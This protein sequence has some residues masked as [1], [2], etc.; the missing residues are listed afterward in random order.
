ME[1]KQPVIGHV[2]P[3]VGAAG[4]HLDVLERKH[5]RGVD[6]MAKRIDEVTAEVKELRQLLAEVISDLW[7]T[8][9]H[10]YRWQTNELVGRAVRALGIDVE[11][12]STWEALQALK[13]GRRG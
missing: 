3:V 5:V 10:R 8:E 13:E 7:G 9:H 6:S 12:E 2:S 4:D 11:N 1:R